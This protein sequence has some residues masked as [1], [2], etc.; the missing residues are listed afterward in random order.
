M[1]ETAFPILLVDM[2][3]REGVAD[4]AVI[5]ESDEVFGQVPVAYVQPSDVETLASSG[6]M[7]ELVQRIRSR[8]TEAFSRAYRPAAVK[9][10]EEFSSHATGKI[11]KGL[12]RE[13]DVTVVYE[14]RL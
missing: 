4:V 9:I 6:A 12:I 2:A 3:K 14:E 10:V 5:G 1:D 11:R 13:G 7:G 8:A